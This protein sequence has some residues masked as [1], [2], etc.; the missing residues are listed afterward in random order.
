MKKVYEAG[1]KVTGTDKIIISLYRDPFLRGIFQGRTT[2]Y[3]VDVFIEGKKFRQ[4][5]FP[6]IFPS[7]A[8]LKEEL[9]KSGIAGRFAADT[10]VTSVPV[11]N[12]Y[13]KDAAWLV[14]ERY[15]RANGRLREELNAAVSENIELEDALEKALRKNDHLESEASR[16]AA[17]SQ[18]LQTDLEQ[19][20]HYVKEL[21]KALSRQP[22]RVTARVGN[23]GLSGLFYRGDEAELSPE[24]LYAL[25]Y[26]VPTLRLQ[27][28]TVSRD[29]KYR[30]HGSH[31]MPRGFEEFVEKLADIN[32]VNHAGNV[33]LAKT[34]HKEPVRI[35]NEGNLIVTYES[36]SAVDFLVQTTAKDET[37]LWY[38]S[39]LIKAIMF[40]DRIKGLKKRAASAN[41]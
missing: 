21:E 1:P 9:Y 14:Q 39:Q 20:R 30:R 5:V 16:L 27:A 12:V 32:F 19:S 7:F 35:D 29:K 41:S 33:R 4:P 37:Q 13:P 18:S 2:G 6:G 11:I 3:V 15:N 31:H 24:E 17:L 38:A 8:Q 10:L 25:W 22:E 28:S 23:Y 40:K 36:G 26:T 34:C